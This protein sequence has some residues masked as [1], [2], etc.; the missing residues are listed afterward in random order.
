M[1]ADNERIC[2]E[3]CFKGSLLRSFD[4]G[5]AGDDGAEL[6]LRRVC[7]SENKDRKGRTRGTNL[8]ARSELFY[9]GVD[10]GGFDTVKITRLALN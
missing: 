1:H 8:D 5:L 6:G 3:M 10:V 7:M 4:G 9:D 2:R